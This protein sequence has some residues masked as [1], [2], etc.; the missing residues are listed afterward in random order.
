[1]KKLVVSIAALG[2]VLL[3]A[4]CMMNTSVGPK[5]LSGALTL[6]SKESMTI[7]VPS[8][9]TDKNGASKKTAV[10]SQFAVGIARIEVGYWT[11]VVAIGLLV[12]VTVFSWCLDAEPAPLPDNSGYVWV[13]GN[14]TLNAA[15]TGRVS[16]DSVRWTM[17]IT[18]GEVKDFVWFEGT[19]TITGKA[20]YWVFYDDGENND[21]HIAS[22]RF[23]YNCPEPKF[24]TVKV[25]I[26]D[27][28]NIDYENYLEWSS[29]GDNKTFEGFDKLNKEGK[30]DK[31]LIAWNEVTGAGSITNL[32]TDVKACWDVAAN[33]YADIVCP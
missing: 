13:V 6:P 28:A 7:P 2:V 33:D 8:F 10:A 17:S 31:F 18:A 27:P 14:D 4:G 20:G 16:G 12:P 23:S 22:V 24:G 30:P 9:A 19:S 29:S 21:E 25:E 11:G 1:M 26:I 32:I 3:G 15:L 5:E